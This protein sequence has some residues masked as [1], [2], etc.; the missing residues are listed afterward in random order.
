MDGLCSIA[1][2]SI[3]LVARRSSRCS[4]LTKKN[5]GQGFYFEPIFNFK[6]GI[7]DLG[8]GKIE[9]HKSHVFLIPLQNVK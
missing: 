8:F 6:F 4:I 1:H 9:P 2:G 7:W 5:E 3:L